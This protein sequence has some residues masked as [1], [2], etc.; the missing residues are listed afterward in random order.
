[1][2][3]MKIPEK[4]LKIKQGQEGL[5]AFIA[6]GEVLVVQFFFGIGC[7]KQYLLWLS[8]NFVMSSADVPITQRR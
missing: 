5:T 3:R 4:K 2:E 1:M 8:L 7:V 6:I